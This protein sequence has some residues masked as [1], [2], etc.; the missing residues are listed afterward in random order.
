MFTQEELVE[1]IKGLQEEIAE[2]KDTIKERD[3]E[4]ESLKETIA[5]IRSS[6]DSIVYDLNKLT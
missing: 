1:E 2:Q 3:V 4:I 5:D 6:I